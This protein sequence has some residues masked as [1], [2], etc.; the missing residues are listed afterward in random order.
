M[1]FDLPQ[2]TEPLSERA[3][4]IQTMVVQAKHPW[5][6]AVPQQRVADAYGLRTLLK[7]KSGRWR[8]PAAAPGQCHVV[9]WAQRCLTQDLTAT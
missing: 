9:T 7:M 5:L 1:I 3:H 8:R 4:G 6:Q 2:A